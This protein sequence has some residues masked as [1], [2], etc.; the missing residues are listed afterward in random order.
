MILL[1]GSLALIAYTTQTMIEVGHVQQ[2]KWSVLF[3]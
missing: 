2:H 1:G 3:I